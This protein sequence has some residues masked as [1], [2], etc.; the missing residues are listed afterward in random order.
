MSPPRRR[1][2]HVA[3]GVLLRDDGH[4]LLADRPQGKPYAGYWE[5]PGGKIEDGEHVCRA[6]E[7]ELHEEL[8]IEIEGSAP[9]VTFVH[10]YPHALVELQFRIVRRWRGEPH[11]REGQ[12]LRFV[13]PA[14]EP[15]Q[16][17]LPAAVPALR[18]LRLPASILVG[19]KHAKPTGAASAAVGEAMPESTPLLIVD[20]EGCRLGDGSSLELASAT[21]REGKGPIEAAQ[22]T[23]VVAEVSDSAA[24]G[25]A[26]TRWTGAWVDSEHDLQRA[27][28]EGSDFAL[29]R[30]TGL[31]ERLRV[32]PGPLPVYV[33]DER[34]LSCHSP[35][36]IGSVIRWVGLHRAACDSED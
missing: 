16:P 25:S 5:F 4:V 20:A 34:L 10:D 3:V 7:R 15:P 18:W 24:P 6:L 12:R 14:G 2:T 33:P 31:A 35:D 8:G 1:L 36:V 9:W 11:P 28:R 32:V 29:V 26:G 13:D 17:L 27:S 22:A 19:P 23:W 21:L 30:S